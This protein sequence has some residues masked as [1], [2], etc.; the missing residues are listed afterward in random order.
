MLSVNITAEEIKRHG[1]YGC[2]EVP[3]EFVDEDGIY[4]GVGS[5]SVTIG[6]NTPLKLSPTYGIPGSVVQR[7]LDDFFYKYNSVSW[8]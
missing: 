7:V 5:L 3:Y 6:C 4:Y 8:N 1:R 2:F